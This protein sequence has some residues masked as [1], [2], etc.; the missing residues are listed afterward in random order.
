MQPPFYGQPWPGV[1][2][3]DGGSAMFCHQAVKPALRPGG[4]RTSSGRPRPPRPDCRPA[5]R[6]V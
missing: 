3:S 2:R 1:K 5:R 4:R 6:T